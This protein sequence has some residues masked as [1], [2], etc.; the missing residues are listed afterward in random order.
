MGHK[1]SDYFQISN[2]VKQGG[3]IPSLLF[4]CFID[5]LF[6]QLQH[7]DLGC[8][9][10][11]SYAGAFGY[12]D[13]IALLGSTQLLINGEKI[14]VVDSDKHLG[15]FTATNIAYRNITENVCDL[16]KR[17]NWIISDFRLCVL[18]CIVL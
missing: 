3:V 15:N 9:V 14:S 8:R 10:G 13:D 11:C 17:S 16:H 12:V 6:T 2:G 7:S 18:Y 1:Q 5:N 4:S